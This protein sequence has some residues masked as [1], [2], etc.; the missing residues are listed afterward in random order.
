MLYKCN[1]Y[2]IHGMCFFV[3]VVYF[4]NNNILFD[5]NNIFLDSFKKQKWVDVVEAYGGGVCA[6]KK[7]VIRGKTLLL[8][9]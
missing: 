9:R 8:S 6:L 5:C 4:N 1:I 3:V 2:S 7:Y